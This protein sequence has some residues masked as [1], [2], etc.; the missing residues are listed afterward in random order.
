MRALMSKI[1]QRWIVVA[2]DLFMVPVAWL[3]AYWLRFNL[4]AFP[5]HMFIQALTDLPFVLVI[6]AGALWFF[7]VY[8]GIIVTGSVRA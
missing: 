4:E 7:G 3:G 8:R 5:A 1:S 2:H 6:Q